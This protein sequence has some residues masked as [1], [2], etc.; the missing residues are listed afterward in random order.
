MCCTRLA[1]NTGR[2]N[3]AKITQKNRDMRTIAQ[4]CLAIQACTNNRKN[5]LN[6]NIS[7]TRPHN[8]AN[9]GPLAAI[10]W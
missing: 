6:G 7:S 1:G 10:D 2:K 5:L 3:Y 4:L 9:F 8:M